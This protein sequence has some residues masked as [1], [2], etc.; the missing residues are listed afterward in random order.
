MSANVPMISPNPVTNWYHLHSPLG[1]GYGAYSSGQLIQ[2]DFLKTKLGG[3]F[4]Y[5][6]CIDS[7]KFLD[8]QKMT[9]YA[10]KNWINFNEISLNHN[11]Y[12]GLKNQNNIF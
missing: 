5:T 1:R 8:P 2:V 3:N 4:D 11:H 10:E 12:W 7:N 6:Q 9:A